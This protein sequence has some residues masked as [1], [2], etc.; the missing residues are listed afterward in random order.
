[1]SRKEQNHFSTGLARYASTAAFTTARSISSHLRAWF[2]NTYKPQYRFAGIVFWFD[3]FLLGV[4]VAL[5]ILNAF[6]LVTILRPSPV[7]ITLDFRTP[8]TIH[9]SDATP[10]EATLHVTDGKAHEGIVLRVKFPDWVEILSS[11]PRFVKQ[12]IQ[13]GALRPGDEK[14]ARFIVRI[15]A[16]KGTKVPF[17][18]EISQ[19]GFFGIPSIVSG[20][21]TRTV[22]FEALSI[23]PAVDAI[24]IASGGSVPY[25]VTNVGSVSIPLVTVRLVQADGAPAARLDSGDVLFLKNVSAK[26]SRLVFLQIGETSAT[27]VRVG[28]EVQ[29]GAQVVASDA[30]SYAIESSRQHI[31]IREPLRSTLSY[32]N[33]GEPA[34][35]F[36]A[37]ALLDVDEPYQIFPLS[38]GIGQISLPLDPSRAASST[39]WSV[40]P[41]SHSN[42]L[43][44]RVI[45]HMAATF[46]FAVEARYFSAIG[47]Q[48]GIGPLPPKIGEVTSYW[49]VWTVGPVES[50]LRLLL[51]SSTL[52]ANV[53]ATGKF[54]SQFGGTF[55]TNG[56]TVSW[57]VP[58]V[59]VTGAAATFAFEIAFTPTKN[60]IGTMA[61]LIT[62]SVANAIA[63]QN[64]ETLEADALTGVGADTTDLAHD[65]TGKGKGIIR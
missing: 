58:S 24:A 31:T 27:S 16:A 28:L 29:D 50:E 52:P 7:G 65:A 6:F 34:R 23:A 11:E 56:K 3:V 36:V 48:L 60:Q 35:L 17:G 33:S 21:E 32:E 46:P 10:I 18:F 47:D 45:G 49:I 43:G 20:R 54:A 19:P 41:I 14:V 42:V 40:I 61:R 9:G 8:S 38:T 39:A 13:I 51:M 55:S 63:A 44:R 15:R 62:S 22:D 64:G 4:A 5:L 53:R 1:M 30:R 2:H 59:P 25:V 12:A 57:T 37:H 26:S